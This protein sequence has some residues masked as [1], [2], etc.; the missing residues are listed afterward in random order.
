M[1]KEIKVGLLGII[2]LTILYL[3]FNFLKGLDI[4]RTENEYLAYYD[5]VEGLQSSNPVMYHG[6][7]VG[8]VVSVE[9]QQEK[10]RV[11]VRIAVN[12]KIKITD[13]TV[14][15]L[16]DNGL[17]GGKMIKLNLVAGNE[18]ADEGE[19]PSVV[20]KGLMAGT[21]D[22][23]SP[24]LANVDSLVLTLNKTIKQFDQ[25][26]TAL[27][28]LMAG[29]TQTTT[30]VNGVI[31]SNSKNLNTITGETAALTKNLNVIAANLD[32]Q[33]KPILQKT[34]TFADSLNAVKLGATV[35]ELNRSVAGLQGILNDINSGKGTVGKLA[36]DDSLYVNLDKTASNLS[37]LLGD[38]KENPKRYVHFSLFGKKDKK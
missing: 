11:E 5:E 18:L 9:P 6:V 2:S 23:L 36:K 7:T 17:L 35:S 21:M 37:K 3:G 12:R 8:R 32:S 31:A 13:K 14:A 34:N 10:N 1:S 15:V 30:G 24:T 27:K 28:V 20:E 26:G 29:A 22:K 16:A 4:F 25:T 33:I 19:M 38:M